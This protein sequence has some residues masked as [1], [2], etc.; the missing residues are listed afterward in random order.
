V[1]GHWGL[2]AEDLG[3]LDLAID[4]AAWYPME[5]YARPMRLLGDI[6]GGGKEAYFADPVRARS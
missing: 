5:S 3:L 4:P 6:E 2:A 1:L